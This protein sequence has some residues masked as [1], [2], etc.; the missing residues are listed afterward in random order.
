[1]SDPFLP[2]SKDQIATIV[3]TLEGADAARIPEQTVVALVGVLREERAGGL[4]GDA[5][6]DTKTARKRARRMG[7]LTGVAGI[8][9]QLPAEA[10]QLVEEARAAV[11]IAAVQ[12]PSRGDA[13]I[14]ADL[15]VLW[16]LL[17]DLATAE[18]ITAATPAASLLDH[19]YRTNADK[20]REAVPEKWT[21]IATLKFL[22]KMRELRNVTDLMPGGIVRN[23][24]VV[25][26]VPTALGA[27]R[28]MKAFQ[29]DLERH[30]AA[31]GQQQPPT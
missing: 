17:D 8:L 26:A 15:L 25:G 21:P 13:E 7:A 27:G 9:G 5:K 16:G 3:R 24:P 11:D 20:V 28:D 1:M 29:K 12:A 31:L 22:W 19:L 6:Q 18:A 30:Y 14:A 2:L 23:I 4:P 10:V